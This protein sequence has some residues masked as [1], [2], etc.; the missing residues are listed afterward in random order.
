MGEN[1][2]TQAKAL[3]KKTKICKKIVGNAIE[4]GDTSAKTRSKIKARL[5]SIE[6]E[7]QQLIDEFETEAKLV[8]HN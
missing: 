1:T 8:T 5:E 2:A 3:L 7:L 4:T 6:A